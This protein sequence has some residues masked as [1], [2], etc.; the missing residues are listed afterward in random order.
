MSDY[1]IQINEFNLGELDEPARFSK[2]EAVCLC[3]SIRSI[4]PLIN[5]MHIKYYNARHSLEVRTLKEIVAIY[6]K[7]KRARAGVDS[8]N[9]VESP[10]FYGY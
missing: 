4:S 5:A 2:G 3:S 7:K 8:C 6:D 9:T 1:V 10:G